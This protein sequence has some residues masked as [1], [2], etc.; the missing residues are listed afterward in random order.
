MINHGN[1][2]EGTNV[3]K[4]I[5]SKCHKRFPMF[6]PQQPTR[7]KSKK[8][9]DPV[10]KCPKIIT[11]VK[12][13]KV[14]NRVL[15]PPEREA[16]LNHFIKWFYDN[17]TREAVLCRDGTPVNDIRVLDLMDMFSFSIPDLEILFKNNI[18][19]GAGHA[20]QEEAR[21]F[22]RVVTRALELKKKMAE[23]KESI[24]AR[25]KSK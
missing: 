12:P 17:L 22:A 2:S 6:K 25:E 8:E 13:T 23:L 20:T 9:I 15:I 18:R 24:E 16:Y 10:T 1:H 5:I 4:L 3:E 7:R 11:Y 14:V 19:M 21:L